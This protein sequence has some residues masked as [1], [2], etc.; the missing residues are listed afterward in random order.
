MSLS[1]SE[2]RDAMK[3]KSQIERTAHH[4]AGHLVVE[5]KISGGLCSGEVTIRPRPV[6]GILGHASSEEPWPTIMHDDGPVSFDPEV[7]ENEILSLYA[8]LAAESR[9][10]P[11][12]TDPRGAWA[13]NEKAAEWLRFHPN[14]PAEETLRA[15]AAALV[16]T[17]W[18]AIDALAQ[19]LL[20]RRELPGDEAEIIVDTALGDCTHEDLQRYRLLRSTTGPKV[21]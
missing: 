20:A 16:E 13:D 4:E 19:E 15:R 11:E 3:P 6:E 17:H 7:L 12:G 14:P 21:S 10:D 5:Y 8:G 18:T 2:T 1:V 9:F